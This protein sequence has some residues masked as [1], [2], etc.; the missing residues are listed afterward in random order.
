MSKKVVRIKSSYEEFL[1]STPNPGG[2]GILIYNM[3]NIIMHTVR[4]R[5]DTIIQYSYELINDRTPI[6]AHS[7][8]EFSLSRSIQQEY[9]IKNDIKLCIGIPTSSKEFLVHY[10]HTS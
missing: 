9:K 10:M 3:H 2:T 5:I 1:T 4:A 8:Y 7:E 6:D